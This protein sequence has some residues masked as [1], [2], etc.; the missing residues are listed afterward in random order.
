VPQIL[1]VVLGHRQYAEVSR[2]L[3]ERVE[4]F[5]TSPPS[6]ILEKI[7]IK[8]HAIRIEKV[9][10]SEQ[11]AQALSVFQSWLT[12]HFQDS[13]CYGM[14]DL[15]FDWCMAVLNRQPEITW[16]YLTGELF[17]KAPRFF[18]VFVAVTKF[19][20]GRLCGHAEDELAKLREV[21]AAAG[22]SMECRA[23][24]TA[25]AHMLDPRINR[26]LL[27]LAAFEHDC[28]ESVALSESYGETQ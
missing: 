11:P 20:R 14:S 5:L 25:I 27:D 13:D 19:L 8:L 26:F 15:V 23:H 2:Q 16:P 18:P 22:N 7:Y 4:T 24:A 12:N 6:L 17:L 1:T 3:I 9:S 28:P 10:A 21:F